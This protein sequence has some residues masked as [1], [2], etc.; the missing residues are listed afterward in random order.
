MRGKTPSPERATVI[1]LDNIRKQFAS[2]T[3]LGP[4]TLRIA[5]SK[6]TVVIGPSG[7]G[8][9]TLLRVLL[10]LALPDEGRVRYDNVVLS[11]DNLLEWRHKIGYVNQDGG[12]FPHLAAR[13]NVTLLARHLAKPDD[14]I[15]SR[16]RVLTDLVRLPLDLLQRYPR[17]LSGGQRQRVALMRALMLDPPYLFLDEPLGALDPMTRHALQG[18]LK[19]IFAKLGKT[20]L[21]VTHDLHEAA[22]FADEIVMLSEGQVVQ[23]GSMDDLLLR[24]STPFVTEFVRAQRVDSRL[25]AT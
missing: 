24:P 5:A 7:C 8:K 23:R 22:F 18:D 20:V 10:G 1:E 21:L 16:I 25:A 12:L 17:E 14:W 15:E 6:T 2:V 4:V 13:A 9:T 19:A 11:P 3:A